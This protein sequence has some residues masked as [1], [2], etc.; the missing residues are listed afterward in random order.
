MNKKLQDGRF[1]IVSSALVFLFVIGV[2]FSVTVQASPYDFMNP[3]GQD[4]DS[5]T[6]EKMIVANGNVTIEID[7]NRLNGITV[8]SRKATLGFD[9][10]P[11]TFF[12]ILVLNGELRG[13]VPSSMEIM[14]RGNA[15]LPAALKASYRQLVIEN[16]PWG[17]QYEFAVRDKKTGFTFFN[18]E[19]QE[20]GFDASQ[21]VFTMDNARLLISPEF[22]AAMGRSSDAGA[23][24]G[25]LAVN[26][27]MRAIEVAQVVDGEVTKNVLPPMDRGETGT[28]PGPDVVVGDLSGLAQFG[29]QSG[30]QVGLAVGTDSCNFGTIDLNWFANPANNHPVIPQ[31]LYRMSANQDR[32]EQIAQGQVKHA[33]TA[34]TNN[35]CALGCNGVGGSNLGS[36]CSDPYG[37]GLNSGPS[38]GSKAWINP[39]TG[40]YP[41]NDSATPNN[42]HGTHTHTGTSHRILAE[43]SDLNTS[44]NAG[45]T[46]YAEAQYVTPHEYV[47]CQSNPGQCNMYNN[48]SYRQ[49]S[50]TGTASPFSFSAV[51]S[52]VRTKAA[53]EAWTGSTRVTI[54]PERGVDGIGYLA[55]KVTNPSPGVWHYEYAIYNMN[56]DRGIASFRVPVGTG[57]TLTN[58]AFKMPPQHP[59]WD[60]DGTP[61]NA[62]FNSTPWTATLS[63]TSMSWS[64]DNF[65]L[66]PNANAIRWGTMYNFR[67]DANQPPATMYGT[68]GFYKNGS[69]I[70]VLVQGPRSTTPSPCARVI[71]TSSNPCAGSN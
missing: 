67:F 16:L 19:G 71:S 42:S 3:S 57:V 45:S 1:H 70:N 27:N 12:A 10:V 31:N 61:G 22:A 53:I 55:Y 28:V 48:V 56:L 2:V 52:T 62:G 49:Y 66:N 69:P 7:L 51:G 63:S 6:F 59:V 44:L 36:G 50:V 64:T 43:V 40:F 24:V 15:A 39:F 21:R 35:I 33:F 58:T 4:G 13:P 18:I 30:T 29:S 23:I 41:R 25:T 37:A 11:D 60:Q 26:T 14:P 65:A 20:Y 34:L 47:H 32:M 9:A 46:Y 8:S 17:G 54:E 5:G 38:L 68:V